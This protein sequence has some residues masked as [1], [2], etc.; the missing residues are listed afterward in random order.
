MRRDASCLPEGFGF[1]SVLQVI[2]S[3]QFKVSLKTGPRET[4]EM[5]SSK[6]LRESCESLSSSYAVPRLTPIQA[7]GK[8]PKIPSFLAVQMTHCLTSG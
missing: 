8:Q 7:E 5:E 3:Y 6:D 2:A 4:E 1:N